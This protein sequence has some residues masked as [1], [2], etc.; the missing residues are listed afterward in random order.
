MMADIGTRKGANIS[1]NLPN[2]SSWINGLN[3]M[4]LAEKDVPGFSVE[5]IKLDKQGIESLKRE[6]LEIK[7][8]PN[9]SHSNNTVQYNLVYFTKRVNSKVKERYDFSRYL[10]DPNRYS[11]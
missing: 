9:L 10:I 8:D 1:D 2:S 3:W 11:Y 5:Q 4:G 6:Q 7:Y